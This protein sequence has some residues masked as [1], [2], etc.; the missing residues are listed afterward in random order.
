MMS[1]NPTPE[2]NP[3]FCPRCGQR[4]RWSADRA[5]CSVCSEAIRRPL[6]PPPPPPATEMTTRGPRVPGPPPNVLIPLGPSRGED[7]VGEVVSLVALAVGLVLGTW[8]ACHLFGCAPHR[9]PP[10]P[11]SPDQA[12]ANAIEEW[13]ERYGVN[14]HDQQ[15]HRTINVFV[16]PGGA[17]LEPPRPSGLGVSADP[18]WCGP[19]VTPDC[20]ACNCGPCDIDNDGDFDLRDYGWLQTMPG[21]H[22]ANVFRYRVPR[23]TNR[24]STLENLNDRDHH[25]SREPR[26]PDPPRPARTHAG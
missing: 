24:E 3:R 2:P 17:W 18:E 7:F 13:A 12:I 23:Y 22:S 26:A 5:P 6:P 9:E 19:E 14:L 4:M 10:A 16:G 21:S 20:D 25:P 8:I 1:S 11:L 15:S